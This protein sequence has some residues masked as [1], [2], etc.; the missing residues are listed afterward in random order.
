M[1]EIGFGS[2]AFEL[3]LDFLFKPCADDQDFSTLAKNCEILRIC[4]SHIR[5]QSLKPIIVS[6]RSQSLTQSF[7][8]INFLDQGGKFVG[9]SDESLK[10][11]KLA[12]KLAVE[13]IDVE[14]YDK[15][16]RFHY[17]RNSFSNEQLSEL[18]FLSN[19]CTKI[20]SSHHFLDSISNNYD[21]IKN[22]IIKC[23]SIDVFIL[24]IFIF[25]FK[26][27]IVKVVITAFSFSDSLLLTSFQKP[28][29]IL[30]AMGKDGWISRM[31]NQ[32]F[33]PVTHPALPFPAAPGQL[34]TAEIQKYRFEA[35]L[36]P[37]NNNLLKNSFQ[38]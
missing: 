8:I 17:F 35:N 6:I 28:G 13:Y 30:L 34:S 37:F 24:L 36:P 10:Y 3:R 14:A 18:K 9:N 12:I 1:N 21:N 29:L 11:L 16:I 33:T 26:P 38:V 22:T 27:F 4:V 2:D 20:I 19:P 23:K 25:Y 31:L 7:N 5:R 15:K 32:T